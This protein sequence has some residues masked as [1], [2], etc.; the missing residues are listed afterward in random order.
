MDFK[1]T[2]ELWNPLSKAVPGKCHGSGRHREYK[3]LQ[4]WAYFHR[5]QV[6]QIGLILTLLWFNGPWW[7]HQ[8]ETFSPLLII[9]AGNSPVSGEFPAQRPVTWSFDIFFDLCLNKQLSNQSWSWWFEMLACPSWGQCNNYIS[10]NLGL[11]KWW[12]VERL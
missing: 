12:L 10:W 11:E 2:Q 5:S 6:W 8:M 7:N 4:D 9:C 1:A 3:C